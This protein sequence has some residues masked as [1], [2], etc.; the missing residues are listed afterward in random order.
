MRPPS[1]P[2]HPSRVWLDTGTADQSVLAQINEIRP[3]LQRRGFDVARH[4]RPGAH[5]YTVW[6]AALND[7]LPWAL[8]GLPHQ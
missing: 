4:T 2:S 3:I 1:S 8:A 5:S 7:A 6:R